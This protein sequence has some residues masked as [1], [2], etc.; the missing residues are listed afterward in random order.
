MRGSRRSRRRLIVGLTVAAVA[1]TA[2]GAVLVSVGLAAPDDAQA[3]NYGIYNG[4]VAAAADREQV[5]TQV[6]VGFNGGAV[7]NFYPLARVDV[8]VAGTSAAASPADTGPLAQAV[9]AGQNITQP[10][11]VYAQ[12]PG[13][14]NPPGY[15]AGSANAAASVTAASATASATYGSVGNTTTA[16]AGSQADGSDGGTASDSSYFDPTLGFVTIGDS[17]IHH[18][19]YG[20]GVL[21][22]DNVHVAVKVSTMGSGNFT[23]SVSVT[24]GAAYVNVSGTEVPVTIDQNGVTVAQQNA[25]LDTVQAVSA[26]INSALAAAGLSVHTVAPQAT[27]DGTNLHVEAEGV[28]VEYAQT[29]TPDGVP[30]QFVR[31][32]L[33]EVVVDNEAVLSPPQPDLTI[34]ISPPVVASAPP[35]ASTIITTTTGGG[36]PPA[37][38]PSAAPA[39]PAATPAPRRLL[40]PTSAVLIEPHSKG[41]LLLAYLAWQSLM[42]ALAGALYLHRS[43][44]RRV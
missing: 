4:Q 19:S 15:N 9:F 17:R 5:G 27:H 32:T 42:L 6:D 40:A 8:A 28:V 18:A 2:A 36:A 37:A 14:Q 29:G 23:K 1:A 43:A 33:G 11:Y 41:L 35:P 26:T 10:Q 25:P 39:Q 3:L 30:R 34:P 7:N 44:L 12:Y 24:V 13:A 16:P 31:H 38:L 20:G 21:V 22:I